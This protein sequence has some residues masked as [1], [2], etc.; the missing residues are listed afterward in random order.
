MQTP[1]CDL[2]AHPVGTFVR[3][4]SPSCYILGFHQRTTYRDGCSELTCKYCSWIAG[5]YDGANYIMDPRTGWWERDPGICGCIYFDRC[6]SIITAGTR[7]FVA[8]SMELYGCDYPAH[9]GVRDV[10]NEQWWP[11]ALVVAQRNFAPLLTHGV[12]RWRQRRRVQGLDLVGRF[13]SMRHWTRVKLT[14]S[15]VAHLPLLSRGTIISNV[16]WK[17]V[18]R[19][20]TREQ[21]LQHD[22]Y[23]VDTISYLPVGSMVLLAMESAPQEVDA[24]GWLWVQYRSCEGGDVLKGWIHP[25]IVL[26]PLKVGE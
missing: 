9:L 25:E 11:W 14:T 3:V 22:V 23:Y 17:K 13:V 6:Q 4:W 1:H 21:Q 18:Y 12:L 26:L 8:K 15:R 20:Y 2:I 19:L 5:K 24:R 10:V 7:F 16:A